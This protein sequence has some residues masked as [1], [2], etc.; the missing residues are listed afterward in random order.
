MGH[1]Q[2]SVQSPSIATDS[3]LKLARQ[4]SLVSYAAT[5]LLTFNWISWYSPPQQVPRSLILLILVVP[6]VL[7][8]RG[9][10]HGRAKSYIGVAMVA[11][12]LFAAG[13][14]IAFYI[15]TWKTLGW[16]LVVCSVLLFVSSYFYLRYLPRP[17]K[18]KTD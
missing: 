14:D 10:I 17:P 2:A 5:L 15:Q 13:L 16:A 7:P 12:W 3:K 6:L 8:V 9:F 18:L 11:M 1:T 4:V